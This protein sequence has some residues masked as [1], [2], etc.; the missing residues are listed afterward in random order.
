M[1]LGIY[2]FKFLS[3]SFVVAISFQSPFE[4]NLIQRQQ[5]LFATTRFVQPVLMCAFLVAER[6]H[7][8]EAFS[9][10]VHRINF[11]GQVI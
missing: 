8:Y 9:L 11:F 7:T 6:S 2:K 1:K 5:V 3:V 4:K 10:V